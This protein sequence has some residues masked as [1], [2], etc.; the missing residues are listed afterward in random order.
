MEVLEDGATIIRWDASEQ[1]NADA[2]KKLHGL[3]YYPEKQLQDIIKS[4]KLEA[5][6]KLKELEA[7]GL[8]EVEGLAEGGLTQNRLSIQAESSDLDGIELQTAP[9]PEAAEERAP[10]AAEE[11]AAEAVEER[12]LVPPASRTSIH[13]L[14]ELSAD[15]L[16]DLTS[17]QTPDLPEAPAAAELKTAGTGASTAELDF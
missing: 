8:A 16:D 4:K 7:E 3:V 14:A 13:D 9:E 15:D 12:A 11:R 1:V 6:Q 2:W 10:E 17:V 5:A